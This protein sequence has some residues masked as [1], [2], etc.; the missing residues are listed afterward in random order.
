MLD[1]N[2]FASSH[3][4]KPRTHDPHIL[5]HW[6]RFVRRKMC[7]ARARG[8]CIVQFI[9]QCNWSFGN[10]IYGHTNVRTILPQ[11]RISRRAPWTANKTK[12]GT[13]S[14]RRTHLVE[15]RLKACAW[16]MVVCASCGSAHKPSKSTTPWR[17][18]TQIS[19][20][21]WAKW[22]DVRRASVPRHCVFR[23]SALGIYIVYAVR[24][25][26]HFWSARARCL[27]SLGAVAQWR[28]RLRYARTVYRMLRGGGKGEHIYKGT[29]KKKDIR[30]LEREGEKEIEKKGIAQDVWLIDFVA[31]RTK[32]MVEEEGR[33][34]LNAVIFWW[35]VR[36]GGFMLWRNVDDRNDDVDEIQ[37][38]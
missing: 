2:S 12:M 38:Y 21:Q 5:P 30:Q 17:A 7:D 37:M 6:V 3:H 31:T 34:H 8:L 36:Q 19:I 25:R 24:N 10:N 13:R 33:W 27:R 18:R 9:E 23:L 29:H 20:N 28:T 22:N 35:V 32:W 16:M 14:Q 15:C 1:A 26:R 11:L 4:S